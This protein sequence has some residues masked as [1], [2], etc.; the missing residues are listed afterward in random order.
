MASQEE[1][2]TPHPPV[3]IQKKKKKKQEEE[4]FL[5]YITSCLRW[6]VL[7]EDIYVNKDVVA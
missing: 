5:L 7:I 2:V 3:N 1:H 6:G 4:K